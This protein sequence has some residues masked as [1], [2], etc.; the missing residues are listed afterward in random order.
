MHVLD[1]TY[2]T[3]VNGPGRRNILHLAGCT[4]R[5]PGCF[6]KHTWLRS[7]GKSLPVAE[8]AKLL[9]KDDPE[10]ISISG[11]EPLDQAEELLR[12]LQLLPL[13]KLPKGVLLFTGTTIEQRVEIPEWQVIATLIDC[14]VA[15]PYI[16]EQALHP[17]VEMRSSANQR[18]SYYTG[19]ITR[20]DLS[21]LATV[22]VLVGTDSAKL[23]GFPKETDVRSKNG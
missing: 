1:F 23:L 3:R 18:T 4:I 15:G 22:E 5:C 20:Q 7:A 2:G 19:K 10:G 16:K 13:E 21:R 14:L 11:G 12:L 17:P 9:L 8:V 6:S